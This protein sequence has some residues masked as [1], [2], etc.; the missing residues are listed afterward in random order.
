MSGLVA[1]GRSRRYTRLLPTGAL[2]AVLAVLV[3]LPIGMLVYA[4]VT[5]AVPRPGA[6]TGALTFSHFSELLSGANASAAANTLILGLAGTALSMA[7]GG[8]LA[9]AAARTDVPGKAMVQL[10]GIIPL[11]VSSLVGAVAWSTLASPGQGYL[12]I[13]FRAIGVP[14][15]LNI[16]TLPGIA[17]VFGLY[18]APYSFMLIY[19]A[20]SLMNPELE[21]AAK[22]YGASGRRTARH[23]TFPLV[24]PAI[25][26]SAVL[27]FGLIVENFPVPTLLGTPGGIDTLPSFI[28]R[29]MNAAPPQSN[30]AAAIGVGLTVI[31][32]LI[33]VVQ[34]RMLAK[35]R[36]TTVSGKGFRPRVIELGRWRWAVFALCASYITLAVIL[37]LAA[38][39]QMSMRSQPFISGVGDFFDVSVFGFQQF[40]AVLNDSTFQDAFRN[41]MIVGLLVML[42]GGVLHSTMAF[43]VHR[44]RLPG[45]KLVEYI[46]MAPLAMPAVVLSLGFLW[47]WFLLPVPLYGTLLILVL[48]YVVR[49]MPQGYSSVSTSLQQIH[50]DLEDSAYTSGAGPVRSATTIT[51]PL[52]R[53]S[54][55][56]SALMLLILSMR[57]L[58]AAVFLFTSQTRV[59]SIVIF[60][61]MD[62]GVFARAAAASILYSL[63]LGAIALLARRYLGVTAAPSRGA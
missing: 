52:I 12:N 46:A 37:P 59:L 41:S 63:V 39:L 49:F 26:A 27:T 9:W 60:D 47:A 13:V 32:L 53:A 36:Y 22:V 57:E 11:F 23:V 31:V 29:L 20:L 21:E 43:I 25:A 35:R 14:I 34:R 16:Y 2:L 19:G 62:G 3:L 8:F 38:L 7:I 51:F 10:S 54:V 4:S 45:R 58:S 6:V 30:L 24:K 15:E 18:Y 50:P 1:S 17:F 56:S 28:Y 5:D 55:V 44:T 40:T 33:L 42:A 61:Y 48:A